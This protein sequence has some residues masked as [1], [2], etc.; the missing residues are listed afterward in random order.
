MRPRLFLRGRE[1]FDR[2]VDFLVGFDLL[3][4]ARGFK[5][6]AD[7]LIDPCEFQVSPEFVHLFLDIHNRL[8][9]T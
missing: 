1:R 2:C 9:G 8:Q 6:V 3:Y 5:Q 7:Q 4:Q